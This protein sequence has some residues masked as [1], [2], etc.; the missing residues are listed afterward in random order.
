M[1]DADGAVLGAGMALG[2]GYVLTCAHVL[3]GSGAY[4]PAVQDAEPDVRVV[5]DFVGLPG[6]PS[7]DAWVADGGWVPPLGDGRG[8]V[9]L[10]ELDRPQPGGSTAPLR[11]L[12]RLPTFG[13]AVHFFG[14]PVGL[15]DGMYVRA[16][17]AGSCGPGG[18]WVQMNPRSSGDRVRAGF[19]GA[20][21]VDDESKTVTGMVVGTYTDLE[22]SLSWMI[23]V[24][25]IERHVRRITQWVRG[26]R[27]ADQGF[28]AKLDPEDWDI[29][30]A[31]QIVTGLERR[32]GTANVMIVT[33]SSDS[34]VLATVR[35]AIVLADRELRPAATDKLLSQAAVGTVPQL[36]SVDLAVD[37]SGKTV[38]EV[39][40][41]IVD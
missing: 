19:S 18:E 1:R 40:R 6:V 10:L 11:P 41:R 13:R 38:G 31:R 17:L 7:A 12:H 32:Q 23:P 25:T 33:G 5:V 2:T 39:F 37:A 29:D 16:T 21:V 4:S 9:A 14:F 26:A 30:L 22:A 34:S 28:A 8:D 27:A 3:M 24:E 35:R 15:E 20:A 36:G